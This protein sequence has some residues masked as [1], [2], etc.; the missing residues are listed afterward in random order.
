MA[1]RG[2]F[3]LTSAMYYNDQPPEMMYYA[4]KA[5]DALGDSDTANAR[6]DT[7]IAYANAHMHDDIKIEY[8][9]VSLPDFL[10]F[11]ADLNKKNQVHC[12]FMAALGYLG[13]GTITKAMELA[14]E[15]LT[16]DRCHAG[17]TEMLFCGFDL[18]RNRK[19]LVHKIRAIRSFFTN[20]IAL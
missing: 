4:A 6:F 1:A 2:D 12:L 16:L 15:G 8:F 9:A 5:L 7:F 11:E 10:I 17:L 19:F 13:K 18:E 3:A 20:R 14:Q